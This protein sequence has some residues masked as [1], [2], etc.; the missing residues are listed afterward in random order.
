MGDC[1]IGCRRMTSQWVV[2]TTSNERREIV[3]RRAL[4]GVVWRATSTTADERDCSS[5]VVGV[6]MSPIY[7]LFNRRANGR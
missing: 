5:D 3:G 6:S 2:D 7:G 4:R 1:S